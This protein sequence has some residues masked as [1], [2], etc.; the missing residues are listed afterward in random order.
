MGTEIFCLSE[1]TSPI[2]HMSGSVGNESVI[3]RESV[4]CESGIV[5]VPCLSGN[6]LRHRCVRL[7]GMLWLI[8]R[9]GLKGKLTLPVLNLLLHGGNLTMS[10]AMENTSRI[11]EMH[12]VF[13]LLSL[14]GGSLP[15]QIL[16]G[17]MDVMRGVL[18]CEENRSFS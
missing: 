5:Q 8:D 9:Y 18:V 14:L 3:S 1:A 11:A 16:A 12:E 15:D 4:K 6:A 17:S 7:P 2:S 13:P 10:T